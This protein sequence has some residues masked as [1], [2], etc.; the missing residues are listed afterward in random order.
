MSRGKR[1]LFT[2][3]NWTTE[4][5]DSLTAFLREESAYF[6]I[7]KERG[8]NGTPHLQGY[9]ELRERYR[10]VSLK[11]K[12][13]SRSHL[14]LARGTGPRNRE[15]CIK[16]GD[17]LEHGRISAGGGNGKTDGSGSTRDELARRFREATSEG[18]FLEGCN[19]YAEENPGSWYFSGSTLLRNHFSLLS[20]P[21]RPDVSVRWY[22]GEPGSGKSR[23][24]FEELPSAYRKDARTKW[25]HGYMLQRECVIDDVAP[26]G[27]DI[28]RFL[29]WFDRYPCNVET[30]GSMLPLYACTFVVTSNFHPY[31]VFKGPEGPHV[32]LPALMR[33]ISVTEI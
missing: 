9:A 4:E 26:E 6:V 8:E 7:G 17:F 32:Q 15:Y 23:R 29:V 3:N 5:Y 24:A 13:G 25:W 16:E 33:R 21:E 12:V 11:N 27:I 2:L 19:R 1:W 20:P 28:T 18:S 22:Y 30:K 14:E 10:F 31:D